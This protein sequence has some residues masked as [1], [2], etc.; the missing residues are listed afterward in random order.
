MIT[1]ETLGE[2]PLHKSLLH[3]S[4]LDLPT[5]RWAVY[6]GGC[7]YLISC[8]VTVSDIES[9]WNRWQPSESAG[10]KVKG[11][12]TWQVLGSKGSSYQVSVSS[13]RWSCTCAGFGFRRKCTHIDRIK[14]EISK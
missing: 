13:N 6:P 5:G 1:R 10:P 12:K 8:D 7:W 14:L 4:I 2:I 9:R 11:D 3:P